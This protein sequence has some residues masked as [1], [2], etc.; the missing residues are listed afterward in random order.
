MDIVCWSTGCR[1]TEEVGSWMVVVVDAVVLPGRETGRRICVVGWLPA[2]SR[3]WG[4]PRTWDTVPWWMMK[5]CGRLGAGCC[6]CCGGS[7]CCCCCCCCCCW[8]LGLR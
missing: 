5:N 8:P 4:C 6:C 1:L 2:V 3:V 7:C